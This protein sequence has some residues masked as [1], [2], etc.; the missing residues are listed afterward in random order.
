MFGFLLLGT[1]FVRR[2]CDEESPRAVIQVA[3]HKRKDRSFAM[4][5]GI[6]RIASVV[7]GK[8]EVS[9]YSSLRQ[10]NDSLRFYV[11]MDTAMPRLDRK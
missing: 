1:S 2:G 7:I 10:Q 11:V 6:S 5:L 3:R 4:L 8:R 9:I